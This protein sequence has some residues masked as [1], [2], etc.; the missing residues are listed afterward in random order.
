MMGQYTIADALV[1]AG[2]PL[3]AGDRYAHTPLW[4]AYTY[5]DFKM[6]RLL[7]KHGADATGLPGP[8]PE[9]ATE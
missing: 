5:S 6:V 1:D 9:E 2:A 8:L 3:E 4:L 7:L